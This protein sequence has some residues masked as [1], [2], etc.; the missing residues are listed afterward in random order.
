MTFGLASFVLLITCANIAN[1]QLARATRRGREF[2]IQAAL[3]AG[4][5]RILRDAL[6][7]SLVL[8][9]LGGAAGLLL[10]W[11][12]AEFLGRGIVV[13]SQSGV[14]IPLDGRVLS[15][16]LVLS[17]AAGL[18]AGAAPAWMSSRGDASAALKQD[19]RGGAMGRGQHRIS[20]AMIAGELALAL[21]LLAGSG[22]FVRGLRDFAERDPGW[23][24]DGL[25]TASVALPGRS[26][27]GDEQRLAFYDRLAERVRELPGVEGVALAD[28]L[29]IW[30]YN[31]STNVVPES[32]PQPEPGRA[33]LAYISIVTPGYFATLGI[34]VKQ[35]AVFD[36][37]TR[38]DGTRVVV[39]NEAMAR[40]FWPGRDPIGQRIGDPDP[41]DRSW[42]EVVAVVGD[43]G[44]SANLAEPDTPLQMY[45]PLVQQPPGYITLA[46]RTSSSSASVASGLRA[47][48]AGLDPDL[49]V[50]AIA[51]ARERA[52]EQMANFVL[53]GHLLTGFAVLGILLAALG[54]YGV[55]ATF[56][57]QRTTEFGIR[58]A[59]GAQMAD[60]ARL[61]LSRGVRLGL[62]GTA[63]GLVGA[64]ALARLLASAVPSL[65]AGRPS[66]ILGVWGLLMGVVLL[67]CWAPALRAS[68]VDPAVA[69][70][71][72]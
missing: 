57:A 17:I 33:P 30:S 31:R 9:V 35:G 19:L 66:V 18:L 32:Q 44:Y 24:P 11:W 34:P 67:A 58:M 27:A 16:A 45:V 13:G 46:M 2:A 60:I 63:V 69:V 25:L 62:W 59:I 8:G 54:I 70:R 28:S 26:Y 15:Y 3:G 20:N 53:A 21:V 52:R 38:A 71:Y 50:F 65:G 72:E 36:A 23:R 56:V 1:L 29:P 55:T 68:R 64:A 43:V 37:S 10:A 6:T 5:A 39:V 51:S 22:L 14:E 12:G 61:V 42:R 7:E 48:V 49:P 47:A 41:E 40:R 4:R